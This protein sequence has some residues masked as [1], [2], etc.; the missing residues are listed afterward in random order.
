MLQA[1]PS[2]PFASIKHFTSRGLY[3]CCAV[4]RHVTLSTHLPRSHNIS[5]RGYLVCH[6]GGTRGWEMGDGGGARRGSE[7]FMRAPM[8]PAAATVSASVLMLCSQRESERE[9]QS[10]FSRAL[11]SVLAIFQLRLVCFSSI[12]TVTTFR[13]SCLMQGKRSKRNKQKEN[14][15]S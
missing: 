3:T 5:L 15:V 9:S 6:R 10:Y 13:Y 11:R 12:C 8:T 1:L 7:W 2:V 14:R 4:T